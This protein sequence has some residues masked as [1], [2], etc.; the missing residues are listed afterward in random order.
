MKKTDTYKIGVKKTSISEIGGGFD[1]SFYCSCGNK[2]T[3]TYLNRRDIPVV[4]ACPDCG[5][6]YFLENIPEDKRTAEPFFK[7]ISKTSR[8]FEI[9]R[10]NLS[11]IFHSEKEELEVIRPNMIRR[12]IFD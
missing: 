6:D 12:L 7:V 2:R 11:I 4:D 5:N 3:G 8:G 1:V 9:E 10:T